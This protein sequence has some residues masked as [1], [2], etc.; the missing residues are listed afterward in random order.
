VLGVAYDSAAVLADDTLTEPTEAGTDYVPIPAPGHRLPHAWLA[1]GRS[2][3]DTAGEWFTLLTPDPD[4]WAQH[5]AG[6][7]PLHIEALPEEH[8]DLFGL[9]RHG[10]LL[11]R[12]DGHIAARWRHG[13]PGDAPLWDAL[14]TI[15]GPAERAPTAQ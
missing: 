8:I 6:P 1:D 12:P 15:T 2:T 9:G 10:A 5:T 11:V 13:A 7:W 3:L 4:R 14:T